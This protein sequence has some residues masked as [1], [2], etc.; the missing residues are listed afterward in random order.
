MHYLTQQFYDAAQDLARRLEAPE[1][2]A[3]H[4]AFLTYDSEGAA[5]RVSGPPKWTPFIETLNYE[6]RQAWRAL[7]ASIIQTHGIADAREVGTV[8]AS[9]KSFLQ[10]EPVGLLREGEVLDSAT[11]RAKI[12]AF[13]AQIGDAAAIAHVA[14][15]D[16]NLSD[17]TLRW[18]IDS[19]IPR[20]R[21]QD[22]DLYPDARAVDKVVA[23]LGWLLT[24][25]EAMREELMPEG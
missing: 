16:D 14:L 12:D 6:Q 10:G 7:V 8:G 9:A 24:V 15:D 18:L 17:E 22:A 23:F 1:H 20:A 25:P 3:L 4:A 19:Y 21:V 11:V 2:R 5:Q 13:A